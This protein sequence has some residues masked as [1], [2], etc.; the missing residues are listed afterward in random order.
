MLHVYAIDP[1]TGALSEISPSPYNTMIQPGAMVVDPSGTHLY[2]YR[3]GASVAF[4]GVSGNQMFAYNLSSTGV[5]SAVK[6]MPL[7]IGSPG[8]QYLPATG[9]AVTPSGTFLYLQD[10]FNLYAFKIDAVSGALSVLQSVPLP[11][12]FGEGIALDPAGSYLYAA[13]RDSLLAYGIDPVTGL[14]S[15]TK[16]T[17][18]ARKGA[19]TLSL[20]PNGNFAYTIENSTDLVS[21]SVSGGAFVPLGIYPGVFGLQISVDPSGG[22]VYVPQ[23]C[24]SNC[25]GGAY[26]LVHQFS[27]TKTGSLL[28]LPTPTVASGV[29]PFGITVTSQ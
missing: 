20:S 15:L 23:A 21:Y 5:L 11:S 13:D 9:M 24:S 6:D 29:T 16:S 22:F 19:Y 18:Q 25:P 12:Q 28:P 1:T 3:T 14:L 4:P 27:I 26:T 2:L 10:L 7:P 17:P 8:A